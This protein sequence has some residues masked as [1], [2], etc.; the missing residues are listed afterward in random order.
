MYIL[1]MRKTDIGSSKNYPECNLAPSS[2]IN[3]TETLMQT[4]ENNTKWTTKYTN[5]DVLVLS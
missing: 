4:T 3:Y 1:H 2:Y 5:S